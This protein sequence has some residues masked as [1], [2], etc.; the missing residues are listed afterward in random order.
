MGKVIFMLMMVLFCLNSS[1]QIV[2]TQ[3]DMPVAGESYTYSEAATAGLNFNVNL[4]G[5]NRTWNFSQ[6]RPSVNGSFDYKNPLQTPY[7]LFFLN[8]IG[9]KTQDTLNL[10]V[11]QLTNIHDFFKKTSSSYSTVG[12]GFSFSGLPLPAEYKVEDKIYNFP[13]KYGDKD[14][15]PFYFKL[16]D[17]TGQL[18]FSY[19]QSGWR[20]STVDAWGQITTPYGTFSCLRVKSKLITTDSVSLGGFTIPIPRTIVEYRFLTQGEKIPVLLIRGNELL[21]RFVP[22]LVQYRDIKRELP[23]TARFR[24]TGTTGQPGAE[25]SFFDES[26]GNPTSWIWDVQPPHVTYMWGT[27]AGQKNPII[28]FDS[29]GIYSISLTAENSAGRNTVV[30]ENLISI[31]KYNTI[32]KKI[33]HDFIKI[34]PNPVQDN[35][36]ITSAENI[37]ASTVLS[38]YDLTG[39]LYHQQ[40]WPQ[41][42][43]EFHWDASA[44]PKGKYVLYIQ[45]Y[46]WVYPILFDK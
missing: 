15:T 17:P 12:R 9:L 45:G 24:T 32:D 2:I 34:F 19:A 41:G 25:F 35:L 36:H 23:P 11:F 43:K 31:E 6:L 16:T 1:A 46:K 22:N 39:K 3:K 7:F 40:E 8:T 26:I 14:S 44:L 42:L 37:P 13:L 30:K 33:N 10:V 5:P 27:H 28:R 29:L 4:S 21:N 18:P 20:V 38:I